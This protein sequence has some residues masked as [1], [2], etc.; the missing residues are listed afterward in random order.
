M[1]DT[2]PIF[3]DELVQRGLTAY[4]RTHTRPD[5]QDRPEWMAGYRFRGKVTGGGI[6][7]K[8]H[9]VLGPRVH[10]AECVRLA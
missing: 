1:S 9:P 7:E 5:H 4:V 8:Y 3:L 10:S 6:A 2:P